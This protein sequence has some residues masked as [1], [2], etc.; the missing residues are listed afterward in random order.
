MA[1]RAQDGGTPSRVAVFAPNPLVG[2]TIE[3]RGGDGDDVHIHAGG[4]GVWLTRMAGELG[5]E[6]ILCG[7]CGGETGA[8]LRP[9]LDRLPGERRL[10]DSLAPTGCYVI[11]RRTG[12]RRAVAQALAAAPSRHEID[13]LFAVTCSAALES[14]VLALCNPYPGDTLP[15]ALY[16]D[17]VADVRQNGVRVIV[18]LSTPRLDSAL[19]GRPDLVKLNDWELAE[20]VAGPVSDPAAMR[21]AA[22]S[23]IERGAG[24]VVVTR[25]ADPALVLSADR[26]WELVPPRFDRGS[27]EGCGDSMMGGI[28][29]ALARG[30]ELED[31]LVLG[32]AAG[33]VNFLRH[34]LGSGSRDTVERMTRKVALRPLGALG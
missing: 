34:G 16:G 26:A 2:V 22:G 27:R 3:T 11:D 7:F 15:L 23:L 31:A 8:V 17:L 32:A 24:T 12:E 25:G 14:N 19:D 18:D 20:I 30:L 13:E 9:L 6:P 1:G 28:A 10:V 29:A 21:A 4:Q 33:A 5:G